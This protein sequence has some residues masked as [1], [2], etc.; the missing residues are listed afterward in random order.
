[1]DSTQQELFKLFGLDA[2]SPREGTTAKW[3]GIWPP[4][5]AF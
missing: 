3:H 2:F 4:T 1:M 5:W